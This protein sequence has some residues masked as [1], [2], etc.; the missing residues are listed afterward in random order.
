MKISEQEVRYVAE[1][2]NLKLTDEELG[3]MASELDKILTHMD[4]LNEL[5]TSAVEPMAQVLYEAGETATLRDDVE[6]TP[7]GEEA[8]LANAPL[9]G[10]G[11]FKVPR[12]IER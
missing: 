2:A 1:L 7:L 10:A 3:R 11:H 4:K 5:D 12:V 9:S 6:R 8:A